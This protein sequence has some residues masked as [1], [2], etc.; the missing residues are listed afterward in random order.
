M[1]GDVGSS[2]G[3]RWC[4]LGGGV[5]TSGPRVIYTPRAYFHIAPVVCP[6]TVP[7]GTKWPPP[8]PPPIPHNLPHA[9][10]SICSRSPTI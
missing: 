2:R 3:T 7:V 6:A 1:V 9:P 10:L 4:N 5:C 8:P